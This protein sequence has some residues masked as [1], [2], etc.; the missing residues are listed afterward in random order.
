[1]HYSGGISFLHI[2]EYTYLF[3]VIW[4]KLCPVYDDNNN[5]YFHIYIEYH[6][7]KK[8][9]RFNIP[10]SINTYSYCKF[11]QTNN[12]RVIVHIIRMPLQYSI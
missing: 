3:S 9:T 11:T 4:I 6:L 5:N 8:K 12:I 2:T 7:I 1:M 10:L